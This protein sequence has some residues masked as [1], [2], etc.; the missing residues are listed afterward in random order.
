MKLNLEKTDSMITQSNFLLEQLDS[1]LNFFS[2]L[3]KEWYAWHF[4][5]LCKIVQDS[6]LFALVVKL[7]GHRK[8]FKPKKCYNRF[9]I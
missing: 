5:E 4:P 3:C 6:Y 2:M 8:N 7:I 9:N 1:D